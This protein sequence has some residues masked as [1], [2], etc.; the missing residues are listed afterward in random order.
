MPDSERE[1]IL[2][3][4]LQAYT[5][6]TV[7]DPQQLEQRL[8]DVRRSGYVII[9]SEY[10]DGITNVA[11]PIRNARAEVIAAVSIS[12]PEERIHSGD[13]SKVIDSVDSSARELSHL[14]GAPANIALKNRSEEELE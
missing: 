6:N 3:F 1:E 11:C 8:A 9:N 2:R 7:T 5:P 4:P 13:L 14:L 12:G 10:Y